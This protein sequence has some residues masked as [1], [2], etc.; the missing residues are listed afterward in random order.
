MHNA[1]LIVRS[2]FHIRCL[3]H[4]EATWELDIILADVLCWNQHAQDTGVVILDRV[5]CALP[6]FPASMARVSRWPI[7]LGS[8]SPPGP[9]CTRPRATFGGPSS[10]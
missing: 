1:F 7:L 3:G 6:D 9:F 4:F 2:I 10:R 5:I 8:G